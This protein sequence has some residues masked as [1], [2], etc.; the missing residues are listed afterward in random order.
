ME[1]MARKRLY[2]IEDV[3]NGEKSIRKE[4]EMLSLSGIPCENCG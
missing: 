4:E 1:A 2:G 3:A